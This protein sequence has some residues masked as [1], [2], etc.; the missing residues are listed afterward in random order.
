MP[1]ARS[2]FSCYGVELEYMVVSAA[3]L[4]VAPIVDELL[5]DACGAYEG[6][7]ARGPLSWSNELVNHVIELK[8]NGPA[9]ELRGLAATFQEHVGKINELA[10]GRGAVLMP[11]AMHP[12]MDPDR[13]TRLWP[14]EYNVVY[15]AYDRIFGCRGHGWSNLQS[16]HLNL[17]F[18]G[19]E[20]FGR[21]HAAI[22]LVLPL[23]PALAASSPIVEGRPSGLLDTRLDVY[24][25]NSLRVPEVTGAVIP[26]PV[27]SIAEYHDRILQPMYAAIAPHDPDEVLRDDFLNSRG[28]IVRFRRRSI[29]VRLIDV[30]ECPLADLAVVTLVAAAIQALV[31]ERFS[32]YAAQRDWPVGPLRAIL[33]AGIERGEQ[34]KLADERFLRLF[35]W[36][37]GPCPAGALWR[38]V[39]ETA[40][41]AW[42]IQ[43]LGDAYRVLFEQGTLARRLLRAVG[44]NPSRTR[45]A[46][47]YG[48]LCRGLAEGRMFEP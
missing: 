25:M 40:L 22:R 11:S 31:E 13:E 23:I 38:H 26:E 16:A 35:G 45:L 46:E 37:D 15:A 6:E 1:T 20:E 18:A 28:A 7:V 4:D 34:A 17:P 19:D 12:W 32:D 42:A 29:E 39:A 27:F 44:E 48:R 33:Q 47:S 43:E 5:R 10:A 9:G 21:L 2:L 41:P 36:T 3:T 30:Q 24:R 8:S 14:H